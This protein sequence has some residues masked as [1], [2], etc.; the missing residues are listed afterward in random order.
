MLKKTPTVNK[1]FIQADEITDVS[2]RYQMCIIFRHVVERNIVKRFIGYFDV[3]KNQTSSGLED[4]ILSEINKWDIGS[5]KF[6][7]QVQHL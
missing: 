7:L 5:I 3:S 2:C 6:L 1:I 4:V